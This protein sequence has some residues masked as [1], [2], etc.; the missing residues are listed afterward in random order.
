MCVLLRRASIVCCTVFF[1][2]SNDQSATLH[3][4]LGILGILFI[5]IVAHITMRP[6]R[7]KMLHN[8]ETLSLCGSF[9]TGEEMNEA[10]RRGVMRS[11]QVRPGLLGP[12]RMRVTERRRRRRQ[13]RCFGGGVVPVWSRLFTAAA[14]LSRAGSFRPPA[15]RSRKKIRA[16]APAV[17]C[18]TY[19]TPY[20]DNSFPNLRRAVLSLALVLSSPRA[21]GI[22]CNYSAE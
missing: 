6:Y 7:V 8:L 17:Y 16:N 10:A 5:A 19:F 12:A 9:L 22:P 21:P 14:A 15:R 4:L 11:G 2:A 3:V 13:T 1:Y 18:G 20:S